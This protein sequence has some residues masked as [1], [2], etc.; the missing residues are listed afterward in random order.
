MEYNQLCLCRIPFPL[1]L[2]LSLTNIHFIYTI[3]QISDSSPFTF[4]HVNS[5]AD[6]TTVASK[7]DDSMGN[8]IIITAAVS[9]ESK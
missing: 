1:L 7:Y 9:Y 8:A 4:L 5:S 2:L 3:S 6:N